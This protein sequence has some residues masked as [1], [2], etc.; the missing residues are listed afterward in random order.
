MVIFKPTVCSSILPTQA[1]NV[2]YTVEA[3][4]LFDV[5]EKVYHSGWR[6]LFGRTQPWL[7]FV[8][9]R[10]PLIFL[11]KKTQPDLCK[12][13]YFMKIDRKKS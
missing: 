3:I 4:L 13:K 1:D 6:V 10:S 12:K 11:A 7:C 2:F 8:R 5:A 9:H